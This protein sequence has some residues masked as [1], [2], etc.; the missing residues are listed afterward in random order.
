[1]DPMATVLNTPEQ[2]VVLRGVSWETYTRLLS[3]HQEDSGTRFTYDRGMLEI[4]VLSFEHEKLSHLLS[5][6]VELFTD[7]RNIDVEAGG[8]TTFQREDLSRGFEPDDCF[9]IQNAKRIRGKRQIDLE[10]DPPPDLVIEIDLTHPSLEKLPVCAAVGIPEVWLY[11]ETRLRIL[12]LKDGAYSEQDES[13]VLPQ[14]T[15]AALNTFIESGQRLDR[16]VWR[17]QVREWVRSL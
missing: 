9:Y 17:R 7:E 14:I 6:L 2:K 8:S 3:E 1:M 12:T 5:L 15:A 11:K 4:M 10:K 16:T 13:V